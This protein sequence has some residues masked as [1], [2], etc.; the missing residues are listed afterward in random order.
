MGGTKFE[1]FMNFLEPYQSKTASFSVQTIKFVFKRSNFNSNG[2]IT[3]RRITTARRSQ[4]QAVVRAAPP[5]GPAAMSSTAGG[6]ARWLGGS[7]EGVGTTS[8]HWN[9]PKIR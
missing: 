1:I 4:R 5:P 7:A 6:S 8:R 3:S 9:Q 2:S